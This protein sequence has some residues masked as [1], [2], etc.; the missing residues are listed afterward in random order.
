MVGHIFVVKNKQV[1]SHL[2]FEQLDSIHSMEI[3]PSQLKWKKKI[4][5]DR[6]SNQNLLEC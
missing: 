1:L 5:K 4:T 2:L 3:T 6:S